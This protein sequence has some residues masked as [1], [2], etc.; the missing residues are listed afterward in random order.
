M[1]KERIPT[2]VTNIMTPLLCSSAARP[3]CSP[4]GTFSLNKLN[5][6]IAFMNS[7]SLC[8]QM[9]PAPVFNLSNFLSRV[10]YFH[11]VSQ[12]KSSFPVISF[13]W[14][15]LN[16]TLY[17]YL[18]IVNQTSVVFTF[19]TMRTKQKRIYK[20][21]FKDSK[22]PKTQLCLTASLASPSPTTSVNGTPWPFPSLQPVGLSTN[23]AMNLYIF[24]LYSLNFLNIHSKTLTV[25]NIKSLFQYA[26]SAFKYFRE[27][28]LPSQGRWTPHSLFPAVFLQL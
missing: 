25:C 28:Q 13:I 3:N 23:G 27:A 10:F 21:N 7:F 2:K 12:L 6:Q 26:L 11:Y 17:R 15:M 16:E 19:I 18:G 22:T 24:I 20:L 5:V 9:I 14:Y 1:V 4:K 8:Y